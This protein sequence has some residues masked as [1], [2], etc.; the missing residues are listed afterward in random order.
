MFFRH[1]ATE[2]QRHRYLLCLFIEVGALSVLF[3]HEATEKQPHRHLCCACSLWR[4]VLSFF[5]FLA[6]FLDMHLRGLEAFIRAKYE[7]KKYIAR[8]WVPPKPSTLKLVSIFCCTAEM[9]SCLLF[10]LLQLCSFCENGF[11]GW[12]CVFE[13]LSGFL[14]V[15][16]L[17]F[18]DEKLIKY[19]LL[20]S[21]SILITHP[22]LISMS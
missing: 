8:E 5:L 15:C 2:K 16:Y 17:S 21:G 6:I 4:H 7:Q 3:R 14:F 19:S 22:Y 1:E 20:H 11:V 10:D 13:K 9:Q 18:L 12:C